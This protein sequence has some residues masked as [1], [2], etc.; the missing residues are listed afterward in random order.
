MNMIS[1][2]RW[3]AAI[4]VAGLGLACIGAA[5]EPLN[6]LEAIVAIEQ[7]RSYDDLP[8]LKA[9]L[10]LAPLV[11]MSNPPGSSMADFILKEYGVAQAQAGSAYALL[12]DRLL[13]INGIQDPA[14]FPSGIILGPDMPPLV[15]GKAAVHGALRDSALPYARIERSVRAETDAVSAS[16]P[17]ANRRLTATPVVAR[18]TSELQVISRDELPRIS[19]PP[20]PATEQLRVYRKRIVLSGDAAGALHY[21]RV[22][23][24]P[25]AD[26]IQIAERARAL[27][28]PVSVGM[29][30]G[31]RLAGAGDTCDLASV[32]L[33]QAPDRRLI[34]Q[35][36]AREATKRKRMVLVLDT[37]WPTHVDQ[38]E[39]L[40]LLRTI[41]DDVRRA[42]RINAGDVKAFDARLAAREFVPLGNHHACLIR[43]ALQEFRELDRGRRIDL[44]YMPLRPGQPRS[45][46]LFREIIELNQLIRMLG[47]DLFARSPNKAELAAAAAFADKG[48]AD[49]KALKDQWPENDDT[50]RIY[51]PL[52]SGLLRL[53]DTYSR[54]DAVSAPGIAPVD[55]RFWLSLSWNLTRFAAAPAL[56]SS[57][58]Y[59]VF[60]AAG[61]D[62]VDFVRQQRMYAS[63]VIN[64]RRVVA[65]MNS[66]ETSGT[67][68]CGS[69]SFNDVW[70]RGNA[71]KAIV[72][73]PGRL[74]RDGGAP[75]PGVGGGTSF[76]TPRLAWLAA[77]AD[78]SSADGDT[79]WIAERYASLAQRRRQIAGKP[80]AAPISIEDI[81][82][83]R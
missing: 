61:N 12:Q 19:R 30:V 39:S 7:T 41:F 67:L 81:L 23:I 20:L 1:C 51:E 78:L 73:F 17:I 55:A 77:V 70:L 22:D 63:E 33:L 32:S 4:G 52:I 16:A 28:S 5:A 69:A 11:T 44:A 72:A 82:R 14:Q 76:S 2:A 57:F 71:D 8:R 13:T 46:E 58:S 24:Y 59:M 38:V 34:E 15:S 83:A 40:T 45:R 35:S 27:E 50:V 65:V 74:S 43:S 3:L 47:A 6:D 25:A 64:T 29:E 53:L 54:I 66:D 42:M 26:G 56:P 31:L 10:Q 18:S 9:S 60:A 48:M 68:T 21:R 79:A 36:L 75:C 62:G 37:G 49:L 80:D